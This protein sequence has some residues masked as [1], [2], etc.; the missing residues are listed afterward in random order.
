VEQDPSIMRR[1][2]SDSAFEKFRTWIGSDPVVYNRIYLNDV[3][4][5][6]AGEKEGKNLL[7]MSV[8]SSFQ[9]VKLKKGRAV[10]LDET[11]VSRNNVLIMSRDGGEHVSNGSLYSHNCPN[12]GGTIGD[13]LD[14]NCSFCGSLLNS[15]AREWIIMDIMSLSEYHNYIRENRSE[16]SFKIDPV[17]LDKMYDVRD[18]ALNNVIVMTAID[19]HLDEREILFV[20][21]LAKKW[22]FGVNKLEPMFKMSSRLKIKMPENRK[23]RLR[24][25]QLMEK[26]ALADKK[27]AES[28]ERLL[29]RVKSEFLE[30]RSESRTPWF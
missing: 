11:V 3:T 21:K 18:F 30:E 19:G 2:V 6:A 14:I 7:V 16:F 5:I 9:R 22:G 20:K 27:V 15:T 28:E 26:A 24:I 29:A 17:F 23:Q 10:K 12:C 1:F 25:Y 13:T 8:K 4:L